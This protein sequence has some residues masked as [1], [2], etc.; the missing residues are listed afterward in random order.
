M[1][2]SGLQSRPIQAGLY[3]K[4]FSLF[5]AAS[6]CFSA[7]FVSVRFCSFPVPYNRCK[8]LGSVKCGHF[9]QRQAD[10]EP[11]GLRNN[12]HGTR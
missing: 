10:G 8:H 7:G 12:D 2:V 3:K 5:G 4:V 9:L 1:P 6:T 11:L